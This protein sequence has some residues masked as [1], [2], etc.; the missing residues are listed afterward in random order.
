MIRCACRT[1]PVASHTSADDERSV[2]GP[3]AAT[4]AAKAAAT[5]LASRAEGEAYVASVCFK[6]GPPRLTGVELEY[7]VHHRDDP[8]RP[9]D[10]AQLA[11][12]LAPH[13]PRTVDVHSPAEPLP[14][15]S[16]LSV[17]PGAQVE[18][19]SAPRES[20]PALAA[21]VDEDLNYLR[22]LLRRAG[23]RLGQHAI[24][25]HRRPRRLL[26]T[27]R[28]AAMER[29]FAPMG[30]DGLTMMCSTA[31]LQVCVDIGQ[32]E[33]VARRWAATHAL[34][35]PLLA[36]F[37]NSPVH[38][39]RRTGWASARWLAVLGTEQARTRAGV[40]TGDPATTWAR[41]VLDTPLMVLR[42]EHDSWDAPAGV[43]FADWV[44]G[45]VRQQLPHP[46]RVGDL[47]YH[48]GTLF[49]PV[50]P[51]GYLELRYLDAQPP[52]HW[53]APVAVL[54]ALL[55]STSTM[56]FVLRTCAPAAGR[57]DSAARYGLADPVIAD[58]ARA[59]A[60][61]ALSELATTGLPET[62]RGEIAEYVLRK[63]RETG[64]RT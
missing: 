23:L 53:L 1:P 14:A 55:G 18:I 28:Y 6:H 10:L 30:R 61:R 52:R 21:T 2:G 60:R 9:V 24:D 41:R 17:E 64:D 50:R 40:T 57:W 15:G 5:E 31:A 12:A 27:K 37:A 29:R 42:R 49:T 54:T 63:L 32:G 33:S 35:P 8:R 58:V 13:T 36:L 26:D 4:A 44:D 45:R 20:L 22:R 16:T 43:T 7:L 39:D 51:R 11:R 38:A 48:L 34:G 19:S 3:V 59:V 46:P 62:T 25:A 56:E 47:D